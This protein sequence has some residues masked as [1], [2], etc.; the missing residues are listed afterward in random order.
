VATRI[1]ANG[2]WDISVLRL[3]LWVGGNG[4]VVGDAWV[5][6]RRAERVNLRKAPAPWGRSHL[7]HD[8]RHSQDL[9]GVLI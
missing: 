3:N 7:Y 2:R 1:V 5:S 6:K 8:N 9:L 4:I